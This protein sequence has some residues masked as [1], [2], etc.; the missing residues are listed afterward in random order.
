M[1]LVEINELVTQLQDLLYKGVIRPS[2]SLWGSS[3][4]ICEEG[5][6]YEVIY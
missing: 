4:F 2:V 6:N 5:Q 1:V 3:S